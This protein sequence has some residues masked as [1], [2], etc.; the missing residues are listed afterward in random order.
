MFDWRTSTRGFSRVE[1]MVVAAV[2]LVLAAIAI[3]RVSGEV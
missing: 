3:P 2:M 1:L